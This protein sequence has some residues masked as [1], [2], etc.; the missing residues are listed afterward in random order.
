MAWNIPL[1]TGGHICPS[2]VPPSLLVA[3]AE[4]EREKALMLCQ[5]PQQ[6]VKHWGV[7]NTGLVTNPKPG[8]CL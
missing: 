5:P 1:V 8:Q 7:I 3:R 4:W 6:E 2:C